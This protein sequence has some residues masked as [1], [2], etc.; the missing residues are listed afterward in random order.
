MCNH[1]NHRNLFWANAPAKQRP[2]LSSQIRLYPAPK[3]K[4]QPKRGQRDRA[5]ARKNLSKVRKPAKRA[6]KLL[7]NI[8][9]KMKKI[10]KTRKITAR[11]AV[12]KLTTSTIFLKMRSSTILTKTI[13][14][15][16]KETSKITNLTF[17]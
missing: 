5:T 7:P 12:N 17:E 9:L 8:P 13:K 1:S 15:K 3:K 6:G 11:A 10:H 4:K 2:N 14:T 16:G